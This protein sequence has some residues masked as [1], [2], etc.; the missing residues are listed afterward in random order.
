[1]RVPL[2]LAT[3]DK[4]VPYCRVALASLLA[5]AS[6]ENEYVIYIF[7]NGLTQAS[8][9]ALAAFARENA[10]VEFRETSQYL[11]SAMREVKWYT[12]ETYFRLMAADLLPEE[13]KIV[14]L[15]CDI[16]VLEDVAHLYA[17][18]MGDALLAA[19]LD[20]PARA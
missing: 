12:Q 6:P 15:D 1:M 17:V 10:R 7:H 3:N 5:F 8:M 16:V 20:A 18:D 19:V 13:D 4:Y 9:D 2:L 14:Y 11:H